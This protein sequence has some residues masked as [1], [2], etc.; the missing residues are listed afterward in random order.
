MMLPA[1]LRHPHTKLTAAADTDAR[2]AAAFTRDFQAERYSSVE[3]LC[4]SP[5]VDAIYIATPTQ[6]HT[7][8]V[9]LALGH[10]KHV[11]V[12]KPM[13]LSLDDADR[14]I[15]AAESHDRQLVVGHSHSFEPPIR[16]IREIAQ[17]GALGRVRM[18][19]N[20]CF[21]D[22]LYRPPN[23]QDLATPLPAAL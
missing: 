12:E 23:P 8:H 6:Y 20:W 14:M 2:A 13:A 17:S 22:W 4:A 9:L 18:L 16:K 5:T 7:E 3:A 10:G 19:H 15:R 11:V 21:T 1:I